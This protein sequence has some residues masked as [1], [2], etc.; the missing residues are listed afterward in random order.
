MKRSLTALLIVAM[1]AHAAMRI[2]GVH[3]TAATRSLSARDVSQTITASF[4][5]I[6]SCQLLVTCSLPTTMRLDI[7]DSQGHPAGGPWY[8]AA[9]A[10]TDWLGFPSIP[11]QGVSLERGGLY[12]IRFRPQGGSPLDC[13]RDDGN[14]YVDGQ[15]LRDGRP[16]AGSDLVMRL[17]GWSETGDLFAVQSV[18][19]WK[20]GVNYPFDRANWP[21]CIAREAELG[22][23]SDK[24]GYGF[25]RDREPDWEWMDY[26]VGLFAQAGV[27]PTMSFR[28]TPAWAACARYSGG[29][30]NQSAL[31]VNLFLPVIDPE[32]GEVNRENY[33]ARH[34]SDFVRRYGPIGLTHSG[35][36][37]GTFWRHNNVPALPVTLYEAYPELTHDALRP[38]DTKRQYWN[39]NYLRDSTYRAILEEHIARNGEWEG[40][41]S[42]VALVAARLTAVF[43]SAVNLACAQPEP[44][45]PLPKTALYCPRSGQDEGFES[46]EWLELMNEHGVG[47]CFDVVSYFAHAHEPEWQEAELRR[48]G[49]CIDD[50]G[51]G[52]R[53]LWVTE[54]GYPSLGRHP[55]DSLEADL[56]QAVRL[57]EVYA[58]LQVANART[59]VPLEQFCWFVF[60]ARYLSDRRHPRTGDWAR[61]GITDD[62]PGSGGFRP[63]MAAC[64]FKQWSELTSGASFEQQLQPSAVSDTGRIRI[65]QFT[66]SLGQRF[67][68]AWKRLGHPPDGRIAIEIPV[69]TELVRATHV[70]L[71]LEPR[72]Y[73]LAP[74]PDGW[75]RVNVDTLPMIYAEAGE[76]SRTDFTVAR[77]TVAPAVASDRATRVSCRVVNE[78]SNALPDDTRIVVEFRNDGRTVALATRPGPLPAHGTIELEASLLSLPPGEHLLSVHVNPDRRFVELDHDN[79]DAYS[80]VGSPGQASQAAC[81]DSVPDL[82]ITV[83]WTPHQGQIR[84]NC[85]LLSPGKAKL[86]IR[87]RD[88]TTCR[89]LGLVP[90]EAGWQRVAWDC[91]DESG[92]RLPAG[93]YFVTLSS[94]VGSVTVKTLLL[95]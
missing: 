28:G 69:R 61:W 8:A 17:D 58:T 59:D 80:V 63:R 89:T 27:R 33:F 62:T 18:I 91:L 25:W 45:S 49:D 82:A 37:S 56:V 34:V 64:A 6:A 48:L 70:A 93:V 20:D 51:V 75:L 12:R 86:T 55:T 22:V 4:D 71:E 76:K 35:R 41:R 67:W 78:S 30:A 29:S 24:L 3:P 53:S 94:P 26:L 90:T 1:A 73:N 77:M 39:L 9:S 68:I 15:L 21:H 13:F 14:P 72:W 46:G 65:Y 36:E 2:Y 38:A 40:Q 74:D 47:D 50:A 54:G 81:E 57:I 19:G 52:A 88:G 60:T 10:G 32:T 84:I 23:N 95:R 85:R 92:K 87:E 42:S 83:P 31:P 44:G 43:D 5:R 16:E 7:T 11:S 79:N 66:D